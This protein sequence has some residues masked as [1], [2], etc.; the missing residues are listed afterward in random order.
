MLD[1]FTIKVGDV[2]RAVWPRGHE[3]GMKPGIGTGQEFA[4]VFAPFGNER[5]SL[6]LEN[7]PCHEVRQRLAHESVSA[8]RVTKSVAA[9]DGQP[10]H[11]IVVVG[12]LGIEL[13]RRRT[14]RED[15]ARVVRQGNVDHGPRLKQ[16]PACR[17]GLRN[18]GLADR[19]RVPGQEPV[20]PV[21]LAL[22]E[23]ALPGDRLEFGRLV[24]TCRRKMK[25][26]VV[27]ADRNARAAGTP[28]L[29]IAATVGSVD[30]VVES[31]VKRIGPQLLRTRKEPGP[32]DTPLVGP[33]V[34]VCVAQ[35]QEVGRVDREDSAAVRHHGGG[36]AQAVGKDVRLFVD[37]IT[38]VV[39]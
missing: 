25:P 12:P 7:S 21:V 6:R 38:V 19:N 33:A 3:N 34:A 2:Q 15:S 35:V 22:S 1:E 23:L 39:S 27:P 10:A 5:R 36:K 9:K 18:D 28:D 32:F 31:P 29:A 8:I 11:G 26:K 14:D 4:A 24:R 17:I 37:A 20:S 30:P 13:P 16:R